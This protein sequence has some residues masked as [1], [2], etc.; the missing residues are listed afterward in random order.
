MT[1]KQLADSINKDCRKFRYFWAYG[2]LKE[3]RQLWRE[4]HNEQLLCRDAKIMLQ[5]IP[6][7]P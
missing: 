4:L 3:T 1:V 6:F 2:L 5:S 7:I